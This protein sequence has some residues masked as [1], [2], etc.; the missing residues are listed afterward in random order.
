MMVCLNQRCRWN[1]GEYSLL[2]VMPM[3]ETV[4]WRPGFAGSLNR[5]TVGAIL[6]REAA[7]DAFRRGKQVSR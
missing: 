1:G 7:I 6:H 4:Y 2:P 5:D 3:G